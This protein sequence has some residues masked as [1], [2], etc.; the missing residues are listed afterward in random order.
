MAKIRKEYSFI[1]DT[2]AYSGNFERQMTAYMTGVVGDCGVGGPFAEMYLEGVPDHDF[3]PS[4]VAMKSDEGCYRP[5]E[6]ATT[7]GFVN[8]G[9][10]KQAH[11]DSPE[12]AAFEHKW[13]AYQSVEIFFEEDPTP[14]AEFLKK[15]AYEFAEYYNKNGAYPYGGEPQEQIQII[16]F[17]LQITTTKIITEFTEL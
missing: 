3:S 15:R 5:C 1:I 8:N 13:P 17:R 2:T 9:Y 12:A 7:P 10:G 6:I 4:I 14:Y 16:G 11:E